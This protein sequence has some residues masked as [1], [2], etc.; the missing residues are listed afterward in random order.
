MVRVAAKLVIIFLLLYAGVYLWYG[1]LEKRLLSGTAKPVKIQAEK[2]AA[3]DR[4]GS[5]GVEPKAGTQDFQVIVTRN[6]FQAALE[7]VVEVAEEVVEEVVPTSLN[8]TLLGTV[9]GNDRD[10]RAIIVDNKGKQQDIYQIGDAIQG[11]F[12]ESI[13]RGKVTLDVNGRKEALLIKDREGGGPGAPNVPLSTSRIEP[14][15]KPEKSA[16][17]KVPNVRPHRRIS[18]SQDPDQPGPGPKVIGDEDPMMNQ[19]QGPGQLDDT[20]VDEGSSPVD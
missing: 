3:G 13:E 19:D 6:I 9:T 1:R 8:L 2:T 20:V 11:A 7:S 5:N 17:R 18:F 12:I 10:A 15:H 16:E 14:Q 4:Q